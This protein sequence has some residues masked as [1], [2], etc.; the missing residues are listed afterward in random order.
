MRYAGVIE[1]DIVNGEGFCVSFWV[2]GCPHHCKGCHNPQTWD[3]VGGN[4][5]SV[6]NIAHRL[7]RSLCANGVI[8]GFS[9]LGGEP[10]CEENLKDVETLLSMIRDE[11][12][13]IKI[14]LWSGY[15][16]ED[17]IDK[18]NKSV[19]SILSM[20]DF[21]IDGKFDESLKDITLKLK[22]S[23]NQRI[24]DVKESLKEGKAVIIG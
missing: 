24:I 19:D 7:I 10:L 14:Y 3:Y 9:V 1:N 11:Y 20:I 4:E 21:L 17:L 15:V 12:P 16:F 5:D 2:Q 18:R 6:E 8:R 23:S 22:G 13:K